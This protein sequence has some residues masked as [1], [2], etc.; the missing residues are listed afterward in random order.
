MLLYALLCFMSSL[1]QEQ[2]M[3]LALCITGF[4]FA[5][6]GKNAMGH[7]IDVYYNITL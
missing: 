6:A 1:E 5:E 7:P 4:C 3:M 2:E